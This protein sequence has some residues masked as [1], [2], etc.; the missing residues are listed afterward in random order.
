M[1]LILLVLQQKL[2]F[3]ATL[4]LRLAVAG[5]IYFVL[6]VP[7]RH[8]F[9]QWA[10]VQIFVWVVYLVPTHRALFVKARMPYRPSSYIEIGENHPEFNLAAEVQLA[11]L[12]LMLGCTLGHVC[13][14]GRRTGT[15]RI[16]SL[17]GPG[18]S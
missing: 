7:C 1:P 8:L 3:S 10:E 17:G 13:G 14:Q 9:E 6:G 2:A 4:A 15:L 18:G 5:L 11:K 12:F 16:W